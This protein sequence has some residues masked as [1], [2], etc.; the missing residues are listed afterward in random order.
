MSS[1]H[2]RFIRP[3]PPVNQQ[4]ATG[5]PQKPNISEAHISKGG[6]V[7]TACKD[8]QRR[9]TKVRQSYEQSARLD[10]WIF[11]VLND[12]ALVAVLAWNARN[13]G[14]PVYSMRVQTNVAKVIQ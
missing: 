3:C 2:F 6:R 1:L 12:S 5:E 11:D 13:E 4:S 14:R 9:R 10:P 7:S 8:C